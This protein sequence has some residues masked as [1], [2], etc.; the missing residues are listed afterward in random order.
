MFLKRFRNNNINSN[1][2]VLHHFPNEYKL[3]TIFIFERIKIKLQFELQHD[4]FKMN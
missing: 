1:L 4:Y 2:L 3:I